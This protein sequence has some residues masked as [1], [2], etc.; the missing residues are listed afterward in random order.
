MMSN[1]AVIDE[2]SNI[3]DNVIVWDGQAQWSPPAGHYVVNIDDVEAGIGW[4]YN[5][6]TKEWTSP[7]P[8]EA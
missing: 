1:Y 8:E 4:A 2:L 3:C 5:P 6:V 7:Y